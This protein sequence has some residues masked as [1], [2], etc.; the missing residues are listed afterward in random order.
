MEVLFEGLC[1]PSVCS[2]FVTRPKCGNAYLVVTCPTLLLL[3]NIAQKTLRAK[4]QKSEYFSRA[5]EVDFCLQPPIGRLATADQLGCNCTAPDGHCDVC[6]VPFFF[7]MCALCR[8]F[9]RCVLWVL[10]TNWTSAIAFRPPRNRN[11]PVLRNDCNCA[12]QDGDCDVCKCIALYCI[13]L[14][15]G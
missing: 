11:S 2:P 3:Q 5:S 10:L 6:P 4:L 14:G 12:A 7:A 1:P 8:S 15:Q 9:L 13:V